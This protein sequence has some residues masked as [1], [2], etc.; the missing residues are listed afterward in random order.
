MM[1]AANPGWMEQTAEIAPDGDAELSRRLTQLFKVPPCPV[2]GGTLKP[3]VIFFG[4]NVPTPRVDEAFSYVERAD[5]L[6]VLG[7]SLTVYSGFRFADRAARQGKTLAIVN[8]GPTRADDIATIKLDA[9]LTPTLSQ[10]AER[11]NG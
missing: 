11:L 6:L 3:D 10:L 1:L 4:E 9:P 8:G 5:A 2:C 7:S